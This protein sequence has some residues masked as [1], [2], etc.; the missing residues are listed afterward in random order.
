MT[1]H[2]LGINISRSIRCKRRKKFQS[3]RLENEGT[4]SSVGINLQC[5]LPPGCS[6]RP[7]GSKGHYF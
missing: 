6:R 7:G 4:L 2:E 5:A 3:L 1:M